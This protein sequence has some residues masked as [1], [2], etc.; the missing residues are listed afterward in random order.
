[1]NLQKLAKRLRREAVNNPQK[2]AVLGVMLIV[3]LYFWAPLLKKWFGTSETLAAAAAPATGETVAA[4]Q[5]VASTPSA[6]GLVSWREV[7]AQMRADPRTMPAVLPLVR[8][9]FALPPVELT[10]EK[11]EAAEVQP[12]APMATPASLGL[13]LVGTVVGGKHRA[14]RL[15]GKTVFEGQTVEV[16]KD[17]N[18]YQFTLAEVDARRVVLVRN[19]ERFELSIKEAGRSGRIEIVAHEERN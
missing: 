2:A 16:A 9:P 15:N 4:M 17:G 5:T 3:A 10:A 19:G 13:A 12:P 7:L 1:M 18:T 11:P 6:E 14:A 8:D